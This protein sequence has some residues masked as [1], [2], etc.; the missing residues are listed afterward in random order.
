[1][2]VAGEVGDAPDLGLPG[3]GNLDRTRNLWRSLIGDTETCSTWLATL[4]PITWIRRP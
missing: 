4:P 2:G 1:M 3:R